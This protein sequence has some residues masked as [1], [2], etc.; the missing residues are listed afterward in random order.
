M[1]CEVCKSEFDDGETKCPYCGSN[2]NNVSKLHKDLD[3]KSIL[4]SFVKDYEG[5]NSTL[6]KL[7][8]KVYELLTKIMESDDIDSKDK[9]QLSATIAYFIL[10]HDFYSEDEY[11]P[12]GFSDDLLLSIHTLKHLESKYGLEWVKKFWNY[13]ENLIDLLLNEYF[14]ELN[15]T[16]GAYFKGILD[17]VGLKDD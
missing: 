8:P 9:L 4:E 7:T 12:I 15:R 14:I 17:Y 1:N 6:I 5:Q 3:F 13:D 2:V 11:G 16:M 10:P